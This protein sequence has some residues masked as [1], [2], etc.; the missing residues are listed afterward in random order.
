[1]LRGECSDIFDE[2]T[3]VFAIDDIKILELRF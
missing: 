3:L 2:M 1:M